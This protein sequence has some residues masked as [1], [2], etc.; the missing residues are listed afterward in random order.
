MKIGDLSEK[1]RTLA[2]KLLEQRLAVFSADRRKVLGGLIQRDG[3]VD[4][5]RI[6]YWGD[7]SKSHFDGGKYN[8]KIGGAIV[9]CD[10]Q[11]QGKNHI[12]MTVRGRAKAS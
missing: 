4:G 2:R 6:A 9:V 5:L 1:P 7:A 3:G 12:H 11:T 10:W 8:W